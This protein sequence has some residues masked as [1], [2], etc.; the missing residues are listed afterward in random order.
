MQPPLAYKVSDANG[1]EMQFR[2]YMQG[3]KVADATFQTLIHTYEGS[4]LTM[5]AVQWSGGKCHGASEAKS[6]MMHDDKQMRLIHGHSNSDIDLTKTYLNFS[7]R[8]LTY[9]QKCERYDG[10]METVSV[11]RKSSGRN[12]NTTLQKLNIPI[13]AAL[14]D[15]DQYDMQTVR[16]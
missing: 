9:A 14:Q 4:D 11:K 5:A 15:G 12:A 16:S 10:L 2:R 8:G 6:S 13:P 1:V 7:Y 3:R